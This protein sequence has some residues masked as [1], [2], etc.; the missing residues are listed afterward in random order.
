MPLNLLMTAEVLSW[1][2]TRCG[3]MDRKSPVRSGREGPSAMC[4]WA[5]FST[6]VWGIGS[7]SMFRFLP[8]FCHPPQ[9]RPGFRMRRFAGAWIGLQQRHQLADRG[10]LLQIPDGVLQLPLGLG[11]ENTLGECRKLL[12]N[13]L[14]GERVARIP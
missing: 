10:H 1:V 12:F 11:R 7:P 4:I 3:R 6:I 9:L 13:L 2:M 8:L 5:I 14:V